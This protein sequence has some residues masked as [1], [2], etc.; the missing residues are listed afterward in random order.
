MKPR[1]VLE[2]S[3]DLAAFADPRADADWPA[4]IR[5]QIESSPAGAEVV[6]RWRAGASVSPAV[7]AFVLAAQA[8]HVAGRLVRNVVETDGAPHDDA[9]C[10]LL[11]RAGAVAAVRLGAGLPDGTAAV[12]GLRRLRSHRVRARALVRLGRREVRRA[13]EIHA[14]L[15]AAGAAEIDFEPVVELRRAGPALPIAAER[16]G[17]A[18]TA[19]S[20]P[21]GAYGEALTAV[22]DRWV[23]GE[24]T[25]TR[26]VQFE[27]ARAAWAG[28]EP[29]QCAHTGRCRVAP[30]VDANGEVFGCDQCRAPGFSLGNLRRAPLDVLAGGAAAGRFAAAK[31]DLPARCLACPVRFACEG[32]CP[33]H[34]FVQAGRGEA[35]VSYL[36][37]D[38]G[39]FFRHIDPAM[40]ELVARTAKGE[41]R[42]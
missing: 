13:P 32:G 39:R 1:S 7:L 8:P 15:V 16:A 34:R 19:D 14:A 24:G 26:V 17:E 36:C 12:E 5:R 20:V 33:S 27:S 41:V 9:T 38:Y 29:T 28:R 30:V 37:P 11:R 6:F 22:F 23:A 2:V 40:R 18:L 31:S 10:D 21:P 42:T 25:E 35:P 4:L 3:L